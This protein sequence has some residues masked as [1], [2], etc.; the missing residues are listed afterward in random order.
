MG[1]L[2]II[3]GVLALR[4]TGTRQGIIELWKGMRWGKVLLLVVSLLAYALLLPDLGFIITTFVVM[5]FLFLLTGIERL[6]VCIG[7]A[8]ATAIASY[9]LFDVFLRVPL[10]RGILDLVIS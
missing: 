6:W 10:P 4:T 5:T 9:V 3:L 1:L 8:L 7:I 2:S